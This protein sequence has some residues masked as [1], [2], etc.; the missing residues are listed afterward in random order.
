MRIATIFLVLGV[1][2]A[3]LMTVTPAVAAPLS[4]ESQRQFDQTVR[5]FLEDRCYQCHDENKTRAGFRIDTLGT[6][7]LAGKTADNWKE[8]YDNL[9]LGKMPPKKEPRPTEA[10]ARAVTDWIDQEMRNAERLARSSPGHTRRLN[11]TEYFNTLRDLFYLDENYVRGL[12]DELP[13]DGKVDGFDRVGSSLYIDQAQLA[14]YFEMADRVLN[15]QVLTPKPKATVPVKAY[16]RDMKWEPWSEHGKFTKVD[17][18]SSLAGI[19]NKKEMITLPTGATVFELKNGGI[20]YLCGGDR[21]TLGNH[22]SVSNG[23]GDGAGGGAWSNQI[24]N[25]FFRATQEGMYRLKFR[26]GAFAGKGKFAV[27]NVK[28]TFEFGKGGQLANLD[29]GSVI[30]DAPLDKPRE[31]VMEVYLHPRPE[32]AGNNRGSLKWNGAPAFG[33]DYSRRTIIQRGLILV[34][35]E[36]YTLVS[37]LSNEHFSLASEEQRKHTPVATINEILKGRFAEMEEKR[38][39]VVRSYVEANKPAF[40]YNPDYDLQSVPRLWI[41]S[42]EVEGPIVEWPPKGR[43]ELFCGGEEKPIDASYI[44]EIFAKFLPRAYRRAVEPEEVND[45][46]DWVLK[47]QADFKLSGV[48][49]VKEGVKAVLC[50]PGFLL[51]E[52]PTGEANKPQPLT[53]YE[54]A[55]RLSYFLWSTMPDEELFSLAAN[56]RLREPKT[57]EAQVQRMIADPRSIGLIKDFTGQWLQVRDFGKTMTDRNQYKTYTD[58][59]RK[60]EWQEPY[61]FFR[62]VLRDDLSIINFLD[63]DFVVV[64]KAL[65]DYYGISGVK[66][67]D[68]FKKIAVQPEQHRGGVLGMAGVLT[69]LT[70]GFRTLPVR[71]AAYVRD[72][73]WNEPAKPPPPNAGD[74]PP[75]K[76]TNLTV[77][78]RLEQHRDSASCA[79]CHAHLDPFGIALENY[80]AIGKWRDRQNGEGMRGDDKSPALDVSGVLPGGREFHNLVEYKQALLAEK[81]HFVRGFTKKMLTYALGRSVGAVDRELVDGVVNTLEHNDYRMQSLVQAVVASEAFRTK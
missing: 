41:D 36:I 79:S 40:V 72:V 24:S 9:G 53:D 28:L 12:T 3:E 71:R 61:E 7:F 5:P 73:L 59:L 22:S 66:E 46:V 37:Q 16:V 42:W 19:L 51:I 20:E 64:D 31:C 67:V 50:S 33:Q 4:P 39:E 21:I 57:L 15:Q 23:A 78:Q 27:E 81:E 62:E 11:R 56:H 14:K 30:V 35:P 10:E 65:A 77:R 63:S 49:A 1:M 8:I 55:A 26:A 80:D 38:A 44:R 74:L 45:W 76:G 70:D 69:F 34:V 2:A 6:D 29:T 68:G 48:D 17:V 18:M 47:A 52:E 58:E 43:A 54:L 75:V 32:I 13:Q 60:S 25:F